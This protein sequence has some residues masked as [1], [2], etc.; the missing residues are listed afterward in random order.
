M[1]QVDS[2]NNFNLQ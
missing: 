2:R 1:S